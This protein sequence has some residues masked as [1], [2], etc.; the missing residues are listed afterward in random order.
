MAVAN[1]IS[2]IFC[3][4]IKDK[5]TNIIEE[6]ELIGEEQNGFRKD[7]RGTKNLYILKEIIEKAGKENKQLYCMFLDIEKAYDIVNR[8]IMWELIERL[9]FD[10]HIRKILHSMYR[11]TIAKYHW[12]E[13]V[14]DEVKSEIGLR[15]GC[16]LSPLLC[17]IV[18]EELT[19]RI[20]KTGVGIRIGKEILNILLFADD[21]VLLTESWED[22]QKLLEEVVKFSEDM[23]MKFGIDKCK[24]MT[25]NGKEEENKTKNQLQ[26][27]GKDIEK[28]DSYKYLGLEIDNKGLVKQRNKLRNKAEKMYGMINGKINFRANKYEVMRGLWEGL[29]VPSVMYGLEIMEVGGK[30]K[31]G[32]E[33]VQNRAV[34]RGLGA[35]RHVATEALRGEMGWSTFQERIDKTKINYR[36]RLEHMSD[37]R[38]AKKVFEWRG[39]KNTFKKETNRNMKTIDMKIVNN[40][41]NIDI[42]IKGQRVGEE[43]KIQNRVKQE[44]KKKG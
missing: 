36:V 43:R 5:M 7:R 33:I 17:M 44:I 21:V 4:I 11:N 2:S 37:K 6:E 19:Q 41:E 30:E 38:W 27:L 9:G 34:R 26:L 3:G 22:M 12:N 16:T 40:T 10:E 25:I 14:I 24:V 13:V 20:K 39:N 28:V 42:T 15:Q 1:T 18:M 23:E 32:L 8:K 31:R 35:N 29:A